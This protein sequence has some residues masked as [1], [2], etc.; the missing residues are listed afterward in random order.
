MRFPLLLVLAV[1]GCAPSRD[2]AAPAIVPQSAAPDPPP[3]VADAGCTPSLLACQDARTAL[4]CR[5][6]AFVEMP[7]GGPDG[8][9]SVATGAECDD[10]IAREGDVC[11]EPEDLACTPDG[12]AELR[13]RNHAF[14]VAS[15]CRGPTG[16]RFH[17]SKLHCDTDLAEATDPCE[18]PGDLSC[19]VD[20]KALYRC[21]GAKYEPVGTCRG[22][23]GCRIDGSAVRCDHHVADPDDPCTT[24]G[25]YACTN[26]RASLL[27][28]I[29]S[30]FIVEK[31]CKAACTFAAKG[32]TTEFNCP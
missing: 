7:C 25:S 3:P 12:R 10:R 22:P 21:D 2:A 5:N 13:C 19:S 15:M 16:C 29:G 4:L 9:I 26:D 20:R 18:D 23:N 32:E 6:G 28:C 27:V 8:C 14:V 11:A 30:R 24:N 17:G 31:A 1:A